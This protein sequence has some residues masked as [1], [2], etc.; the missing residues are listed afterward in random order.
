MDLS[1]YISK[2]LDVWFAPGIADEMTYNGY[3]VLGHLDFGSAGAN[4]PWLSDPDARRDRAYVL[5]PESVIDGIADA[6]G[7]GDEIED[8]HGRTWTVRKETERS[9]GVIKLAVERDVRPVF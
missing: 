8:A 2:A 3:S 9:G 7:Y 1:S 6:S 5:F 4:D